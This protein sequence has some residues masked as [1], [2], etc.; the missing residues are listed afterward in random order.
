MKHNT[1]PVVSVVKST[2]Q[3]DIIAKIGLDA[4]ET[5][6]IF[7]SLQKE[8][9]ERAFSAS[10]LA[11]AKSLSSY[12][13]RSYLLGTF[14][15]NTA[16]AKIY[17]PAKA[18]QRGAELDTDIEIGFGTALLTGTHR[19]LLEGGP[20][21]GKSTVLREMAR[22][23][24][25]EPAR[26]GLDRKHIALPI[27]MR[28]LANAEGVAREDRLWSAIEKARELDL[29]GPPPPKGF[30]RHWPEATG[31]PW[32]FLLDGYDE[33]PAE[34]GAEILSWV[35][36]LLGDG[37]QVVL[38][39]RPNAVPDSARAHFRTLQLRPFDDTQQRQLALAWFGSD[40]DD[41]LEA[42]RRTASA[43]LGGTP[44]LITIAASVFRSTGELPY[45]RSE[46]YRH[47]ADIVCREGL[48]RATE[49][50]LAADMRSGAPKLIPKYLAILARS[51]SEGRERGASLDFGNDPRKLVTIMAEQ[52]R[53]DLSLSTLLA[54]QRAEQLYDF[55]GR[56]SGILRTNANHFEWLH[57]TFR[58]YFTALAF[59]DDREP[60]AANLMFSRAADPSWRQVILFLLAI[61]SEHGSVDEMVER[62]AAA[63]P[64]FGSALAGVAIS[65]GADVESLVSNTVIE[66]ICDGIRGL[67]KGWICN[68]LLAAASSKISP[69]RDALRMLKDYP[70]GASALEILCRDLECLA[71]SFGKS[72][73]NAIED[74][75]ELTATE[76]LRRLAAGVSNP[77]PVRLDAATALAK[78]GYRK[79]ADD[80]RIASARW[81]L[82]DHRAAWPDLVKALV[83][84]GA[85]L[86][87]LFASDGSVTG[88]DWADLLDAIKGDERKKLLMSLSADLRLTDAARTAILLRL[89]D[90]TSDA[91]SLLGEVASDPPLLNACLAVLK[92]N[93]AGAELLTLVQDQTLLASARIASLRALKYLCDADRLLSVVGDGAIENMLRRRAAEAACQITLTPE[94]AATLTAYFDGLGNPSAIS[95]SSG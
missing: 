52:L 30:L 74:L 11:Y 21:S 90:S 45:R 43:E 5:A 8:N 44:L 54:T 24:W 28:G 67:G 13:S 79:E 12:N 39:S 9:S 95:R 72:G 27:K 61:G 48:T 16:A 91:L 10:L 47:F 29:D 80:L 51:M 18:R 3:R 77:L 46:L 69:L 42:F 70:G 56:H 1:G 17:V 87:A 20:G 38:S 7:V 75:C 41:F 50:E 25:T 23:A 65:E 31:A 4:E 89:M 81:A 22:C 26:I 40:C 76:S 14:A 49:D 64:P 57:P 63:A 83:A 88:Q 36:E 32:L 86:L 55:L 2:A 19:L 34:R 62:L 78:L 85:E 92:R 33:V 6:G 82:K 73:S 59:A 94:Q 53:S 35:I 15:G 58:E 60:T 71:I 84:G 68:R 37:D 66:Q 93:G